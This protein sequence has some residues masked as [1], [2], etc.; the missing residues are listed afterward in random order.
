MAGVYAANFLCELQFDVFDKEYAKTTNLVKNVHKSMP[1]T[2]CPIDYIF[3][4]IRGVPSK[5]IG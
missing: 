4:T 5:H 3:K 1:K 2:V